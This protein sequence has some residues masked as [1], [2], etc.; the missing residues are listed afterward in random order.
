MK[1]FVLGI[2]SDLCPYPDPL[3]WPLIRQTTGKDNELIPVLHG[4]FVCSGALTQRTTLPEVTWREVQFYYRPQTDPSPK[5][6]T[7]T[8]NN[9]IKLV[10]NSHNRL[11]LRKFFLYINHTND[12][13]FPINKLS[14]DSWKLD[15]VYVW[16]KI[17]KNNLKHLPQGLQKNLESEWTIPFAKYRTMYENYKMRDWVVCVCM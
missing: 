8:C 17:P 6:N 13:S 14:C 3:P 7:G 9:F 15:N 16:R 4:F 5:E 2:G 11:A 12:Q 1:L 10:P